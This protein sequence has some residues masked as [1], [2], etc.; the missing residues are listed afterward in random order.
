MG[1]KLKIKKKFIV[2]MDRNDDLNRSLSEVQISVEGKS[3][4]DA[5]KRIFNDESIRNLVIN[6]ESLILCIS[7][8]SNSNQ[9]RLFP[10]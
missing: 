6:G 5:I 8:V 2:R 4:I 7:K 9:L 10:E 1:A 3:F